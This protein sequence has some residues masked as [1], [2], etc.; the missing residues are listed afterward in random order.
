MRKIRDAYKLGSE[1]QDAPER[2][3]RLQRA[4]HRLGKKSLAQAQEANDQLE[5]HKASQFEAAVGQ[6]RGLN[7]QALLTLQQAAEI[8]HQA[9]SQP[10]WGYEMVDQDGTRTL[11]WTMALAAGAE[12][13]PSRPGRTFLT[14]RLGSLRIDS[15]D[16]PHN[17]HTVRVDNMSL[18]CSSPV[19]EDGTVGAPSTT[20]WINESPYDP[21]NIELKDDDEFKGGVRIDLDDKGNITK[22]GMKR[23]YST[24]YIYEDPTGINA[25]LEEIFANA[26]SSA[27]ETAQAYADIARS[28][29]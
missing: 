20:I 28:I 2:A 10:K 7:K 25:N 15:T 29:N 8:P 24:A 19:A 3:G 27:A 9:E 13:D 26:T 21:N 12:K 18:I 23:A 14:R 16:W 11:N 17:G 1:G 22:F 5:K 6:A 4:A